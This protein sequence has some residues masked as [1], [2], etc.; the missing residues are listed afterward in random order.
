VG[1]DAVTAAGL[2]HLGPLL[3]VVVPLLGALLLL[4]AARRG[5]GPLDTVALTTTAVA[6]AS[7]VA[8]L[9]AVLA[10]GRVTA[11]LPLVLG[12]VTFSIDGV[13]LLFALVATFLWLCATLHAGAYLRHDD[14]PLRFHLT[15]LVALTAMLGLVTAGDLV[16]LYVFFEWLGLSAYLLVVHAGGAAAE[17]AGVK[18]LVMTLLGGFAVL[19]GVLL[20]HALGG[21]DLATPLGIEVGREGLRAAAAVLLVLGFGVKAGALGLHIWLPDAHTAAPA[22]ASALLSG[23]MIKAGAY[24]IFRTVA[25]LYGADGEAAVV[26][27]GQGEAL[28]LALLGWGTATM[29]IG[30]VM[31]LWQR[32][33]KRLLAYSSV[34]Q[35][36]F[37]LVGIGA[38][39]FLG[40]DGAIGYSGALL[41]VVNHGLFKALLFLALGAVIHA[42]GSGDMARLGGLARRMPWTFAFVVVAAAGI[43]GVPFFNG[44]V[45]KSVL[46][47]ALEYA[48]AAG[49]GPALDFAERVFTLTTVGTAAALIKLVT[50]V[51]L[52]RPRSDAARTGVEAPARMLAA[53]G[54]LSFAVVA[55]GLRPQALSP[56]LARGLETWRL[57]TVDVERWLT[58]PIGHGGDLQAALLALSLGAL[59]HVV[60]ARTRAYDRAPPIWLSQDRLVLAA[61]RTSVLAVQRIGTLRA[62]LEASARGLA[63][64]VGE[65]VREVVLRTPFAAGGAGVPPSERLHDGARRLDRAWR[66]L[67]RAAE[68]WAR[69]LDRTLRLREGRAEAPAPDVTAL[70][71]ERLVLATRRRIQ[72]DSRDIGLAMGVLF[73]MW[74]LFLASLLPV[75]RG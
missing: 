5:R 75:A 37:I 61:I 66:G 27:V 33:A 18:Y 68:G 35:M 22:P 13:G 6:L 23:V 32:E 67:L 41:H 71:R 45:S 7:A 24:G 74:L 26:A 59:V 1:R 70:D 15:S 3:L 43:T 65:G 20:V 29:S 28:G 14:R 72:R 63:P 42:T 52:G 19:A 50:M 69:R 16:T 46:H 36:G 40:E 55:V 12:Q 21:G 47:H 34:S 25:S 9:P 51:F 62:T 44:F 53:M 38:A 60:L 49:H 4:P 39:R 48:A 56:L 2:T 54:V 57:P 30:V 64:R 8:L 10:H 31:A 17:R 73:T 11:V 58:S